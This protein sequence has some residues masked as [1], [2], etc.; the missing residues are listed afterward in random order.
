[1]SNFFVENIEDLTLDNSNF[2]EVLFTT[3]NMQLVLMSLKPKEDIGEEIHDVDQFFR[4]EDGEGLAVI[5]GI[6]NTIS[7][8][9]SIIVPANTKHNIINTGDSDLLLYSIYSPPK[10]NLNTVHVSKSEAEKD[11]ESFNGQVD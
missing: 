5:N 11:N 2:R 4:I 1:M 7:D 3:K 6:E 8:G 10:H 9:M